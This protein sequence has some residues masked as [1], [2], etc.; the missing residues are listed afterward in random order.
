[1]NFT[2]ISESKSALE[3]N[4][5]SSKKVSDNLPI[6]GLKVITDKYKNIR[7]S[8]D[9]SQIESNY[10]TYKVYR[11]DLTEYK[12]S[13]KHKNTFVY[14]LDN[15]LEYTKNN[16]LF[17][18]SLFGNLFRGP[19]A[20]YGSRFRYQ[21]DFYGRTSAVGGE[22]IYMKQ[23]RPISYF[24]DE[25]SLKKKFYAK[26]IYGNRFELFYQQVFNE[27]FKGRIEV[28]AGEKR[29]DRPVHLGSNLKF[30]YAILDDKFIQLSLSKI[31][32]LKNSKLSD[33][34]GYFDYNSLKV[35]YIFE[36]LFDFIISFSYG[37]SVEYEFD[38][39][40]GEKLQMGTDLFGT[41]MSYLIGNSLLSFSGNLQNTNTSLDSFKLGAGVTW[42]L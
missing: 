30:G 3:I 41:E 23:T 32:E 1:M 16:N 27:R 36:P 24:N 6:I 33:N 2:N 20:K 42:D 19:L 11:K 29:N 9:L 21:R 13:D 7:Y 15:T 38:P 26:S 17:S 40:N 10:G 37:L 8:G 22:I 25:D 14:F 34:R 35:T 28:F 18:I 39:R 5:K 12:L 4:D 31:T